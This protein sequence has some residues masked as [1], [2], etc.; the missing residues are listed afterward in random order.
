[1]WKVVS[2]L[3]YQWRY[4]AL[5]NVWGKAVCAFSYKNMNKIRHE[6]KVRPYCRSHITTEGQSVSSSWC[7]APFGAGDQ[8]L[9]L[10]E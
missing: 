3:V 4:L 8:M 6:E 7:L 9:L 1:M 2:V 10:F 5:F